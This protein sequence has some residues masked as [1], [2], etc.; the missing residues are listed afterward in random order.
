MARNPSRDF[1]TARVV[2]AATPLPIWNF[3]IRERLHDLCEP[4]VPGLQTLAFYLVGL[5]P[6]VAVVLLA[7]ALLII[8]GYH[9]SP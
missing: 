5:F 2:N 4:V 9:G 3:R 6:L 8:A 1:P 7:A